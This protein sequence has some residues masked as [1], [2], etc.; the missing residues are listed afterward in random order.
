MSDTLYLRLPA[1]LPAPVDGAEPPPDPGI[2]WVVLDGTGAR[3]DGGRSVLSAAAA[4]A[5][6]RRVVV[7]V[8]GTEV[9]L[10]SAELPTRNAA[11]ALQLV[12][13]A[14]EEQL[15]CDVEQ[16]HFAVG[17]QDE[18]GRTPVAV[19]GLDRMS[20][21]QSALRNAGLAPQA[22][23]PDTLALPDN[24]GHT[25]LLLEAGRLWARAPGQLPV[26]LDAEPLEAAL[27]LL[28]IPGESAAQQ[29]LLVYVTGGDHESVRGTLGAV[30]S[31]VGSLKLQLLADGV[32]ASLAQHAFHSPPLSLLQGSHAA[33]GGFGGLGQRWRL[34]AALAA[35]LLLVAFIGEGIAWQRAHAEEKRL[36]GLI[37]SATRDAVPTATNLSDPRRLVE[38]RL[39]E[40]RA[41]GGRNGL[42][43]ALAA[44]AGAKSQAPGLT[45]N[46][47]DY[48][49]GVTDLQVTAP[50][51]GALERVR[52]GLN[53][54]GVAA[55]LQGAT[56]GE[57]GTEGRLQLRV[58]A[59]GGTGG[60]Q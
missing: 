40:L 10:T 31:V 56:A 53:S 44:L 29:H 57:G 51:V 23:V 9:S 28:G 49:D 37:E 16:L 6:G 43:G 30:A 46:G 48:R 59:A 50:D 27:S 17:T 58:Q 22:L 39:I 18:L 54:A 36:D 7:F 3:V 38:A 41:R 35:G 25:V 13:F 20:A 47:L 11:R 12:P 55:E 42:M 14:L 15:A 21:W 26:V 1:D 34:P 32:L 45:L 60:G 8:P 52:A 19:V 5:T 33:R 4:M 2:D 24:P